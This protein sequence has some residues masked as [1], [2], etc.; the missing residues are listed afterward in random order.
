MN[1]TPLNCA[2]THGHKDAVLMFL[3]L[4]GLLGPQSSTIN[5]PD[6]SGCT[7]LLHAVNN[8][9]FDVAKMLVQAG[10][11]LDVRSRR[12]GGYSFSS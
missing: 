1:S 5:I 2:A 12:T 7:P 9:R 6:N 3:L 8:Q 11:A 10:A 4:N